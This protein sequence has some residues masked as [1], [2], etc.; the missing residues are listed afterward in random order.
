[1]EISRYEEISKAA[2]KDIIDIGM[3]V[4]RF[5]SKSEY[6][7]EAIRR[8][9]PM[10]I[11]N[12]AKRFKYEKE[13]IYIP[14]FMMASINF[15]CNLRCIGC[16]ARAIDAC[17]E[18][19]F[20]EEL[21]LEDWDRI[22]GEAASLGVFVMHLLGGEPFMRKEVLELAGKYPSLVFLI[23]TNGTLL[24][25]EFLKQYPNICPLISIEGDA[26][27]TDARRGKG[28]SKRL[29]KVMNSLRENDVLFGISITTSSENLE[30]VTDPAF[31][32]ELQKKGCTI[33]YYVEYIPKEE[34][35]D[36]LALSREQNAQLRASVKSFKDKFPDMKMYAFQGFEHDLGGCVGAGRI[37]FHIN[38][39]GGAEPCPF[40]P[41]SGVSM[42][43][44]TI[45]EALES[46][47]LR[48]TRDMIEAG[49]DENGC[50]LHIHRD[51]LDKMAKDERTKKGYPLDS[52]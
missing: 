43:D 45:L 16:Y 32:S 44:H 49:L 17:G 52:F 41:Y 31:I 38:A 11:G 51:K 35:T 47:F 39:S 18:G 12:H 30:H 29:E 7:K 23:F 26:E 20:P 6:G 22:F 46:D 5:Y 25:A 50:I 10:W 34:G 1:M 9:S 14:P 42:K 28:V 3:A 36:H 4:S 48:G 24:E 8:L 40:S 33:V 15:D 2:K 21:T 19:S 13:G 27:T 37:F